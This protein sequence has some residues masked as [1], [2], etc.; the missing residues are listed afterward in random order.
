MYI[1]TSE[2]CLHVIAQLRHSFLC[3]FIHTLRRN[4]IQILVVKNYSLV[5]SPKDIV[6][7]II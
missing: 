4:I 6:T 5:R 7:L 1:L 3:H 2:M